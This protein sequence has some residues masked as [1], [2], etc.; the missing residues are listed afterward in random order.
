MNNAT[1]EEC[2][3]G[4]LGARLGVGY[5]VLLRASARV[6]RPTVS[7]SGRMGFFL[8]LAADARSHA[9]VLGARAGGG[10][11]DDLQE[12]GA[13]HHEDEE[14][15]H[16]G[17]DAEGLGLVLGADVHEPALVDVLGVAVVGGAEDALGDS[18][19]RRG[20]EGGGSDTV[21][22]V[23]RAR[24]DAARARVGRASGRRGAGGVR[25]VAAEPS[26]NT[27]RPLGVPC[28]F[29]EAIRSRARGNRRAARRGRTDRARR[30]FARQGRSR[31]IFEVEVD[32]EAREG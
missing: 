14:T 10:G 7:V 24:F 1:R 3:R 31:T 8:S 16:H 17:T 23:S 29:S 20:T 9:A 11:A 12:G 15:E 28:F 19:R 2:S 22:I 30:A 6:D 5:M 4:S 25:G 18:L 21:R 26:R 32:G 13:D 27:P